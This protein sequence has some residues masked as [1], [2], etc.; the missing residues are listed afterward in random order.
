MLFQY[1]GNKPEVHESVFLAP[2][3]TIIGKVKIEANSSIWFQAVLRGD[4]NSIS[5]GEKTNIQD[6]CLL[7]VTHKH[8]LMVGNQVTAGHGAILHGCQIGDGCLIAMGAIVLDGAVLGD[9]CLVAAGTVIAP[10]TQIPDRS[11]VMG[12]PGKVV[13]EVTPQD[14]DRVMRGWQ[15]YVGYAADYKELLVSVLPTS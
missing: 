10:G 5:I 8:P 12:V 3:A 1:D 15:N 13:R 14:I 9:Q 4:I 2:T 11:V 6:G 7:H